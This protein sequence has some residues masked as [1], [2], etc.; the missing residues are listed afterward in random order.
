MMFIALFSATEFLKHKFKLPVELTRKLVHFSTGIIAMTFPFL[1]THYIYVVSL[2]LSFLCLL[3]MTKKHGLLASIHNVE[4]K[5]LGSTMF[6]IVVAFCFMLSYFKND[7]SYYYLPILI[8]AISDPLASLI[9]KKFGNASFRIFGQK[10]TFAGSF[11]F[12]NSTMAILITTHFI[13]GLTPISIVGM[14]VFALIVTAT[15]AFS[16]FGLDNLTIP[17]SSICSLALIQF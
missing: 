15:E 9:G 1:F 6:P 2:C 3:Y 17:I 13:V 5:T 4:R 16:V 11:A 7:W 12:F 8:L 14:I 10:K